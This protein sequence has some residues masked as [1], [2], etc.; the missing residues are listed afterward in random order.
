MP[1]PF[2]PKNPQTQSENRVDRKAVPAGKFLAIPSNMSRGKTPR[3]TPTVKVRWTVAYG[4]LKGAY[5]I[6]DLWLDP[7]SA[8]NM[9]A[10][11]AWCEAVGD[12]SEFKDIHDI[13]ELRAR[14][15][16]L[17][18]GIV[19]KTRE[20]ESRTFTS[21]AGF[22]GDDELPES[23]RTRKR[24]ITE[25]AKAQRAERASQVQ[26]GGADDWGDDVGGDSGTSGGAADPDPDFIPQDDW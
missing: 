4:P 1:V 14:F 3:G 6:D 12:T 5:F 13:K 19:T 7:T 2:D 23:V 21:L 26:A 9:G 20:G 15:D 17:P 25:E 24:E 10:L 16:G 11:A 8:R 22:L 18:V